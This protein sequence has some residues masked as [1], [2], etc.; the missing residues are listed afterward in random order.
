MSL[1]ISVVPTLAPAVVPEPRPPLWRV[2]HDKEI[3]P[4]F[5]PNLPEVFPMFPN[6]HVPF[7]E[8]YQRLSF[9]MNRQ[10]LSADKW[11]A[12]YSFQR[13]VTNEQGF[14]NDGDPRAN[15]I[16][17]R[18]LTY[19]LPRVEVLTCGGSLLTGT[20]SGTNLIVR[21][22]DAWGDAPTADWLRAH[23]WFSVYAVSVDSRGT[24]R[25]FP[26]GEQP[27]GYMADII[28]PLIADPCRFPAITIPLSRLERWTDVDL[29]DPYRLY[30]PV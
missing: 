13:F 30:H 9:E 12:V 10:Y 24:P 1:Q 3:G 25:R 20:V 23:R 22:L 15:Y 26:Q 4:L 16:L 2:L 11:T 14:G 27:N 19:D 17:G 29:P 8:M 28:H 6:H 5:R 18:N 21:T 7:G